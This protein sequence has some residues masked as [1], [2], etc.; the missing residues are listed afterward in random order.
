MAKTELGF[1]G[2]IAKNT[3]LM[4]DAIANG[5]GGFGAGAKKPM[6]SS[7]GSSEDSLGTEIDRLTKSYTTLNSAL[8]DRTKSNK[9]EIEE[10]QNAIH[11]LSIFKDSLEAGAKDTK[12][13]HK[14]WAKHHEMLS[15][16]STALGVF[17]NR[18]D[19]LARIMEAADG[20]IGK[21]VDGLS[22]HMELLAN[23]SEVAYLDNIAII[24]AEKESR[25]ESMEELSKSTKTLTDRFAVAGA[26]AVATIARTS[27]LMLATQQG[28]F[29]MGGVGG[30]ADTV[31]ETAFLGVS[32]EEF[33]RYATKNRNTL[34][35]MMATDNTAGTLSEKALISAG[36]A[37]KRAKE[38][39]DITRDTFGAIGED[40]LNMVSDGIL[41]LSNLGMPANIKNYQALVDNFEE[42]A[43][44][45]DM[46]ASQI[47]S[48]MSE[49]SKITGIQGMALSM[50]RGTD[51][52]NMLTES[53]K[54]LQAS[55][56]MNMEEFIA[57][58]RKMADQRKKSGADRVVEGK[59]VGELAKT[60][61]GFTD[62]ETQLLELGTAFPEMVAAAGQTDEFMRLTATLEN[63]AGTARTEAGAEGSTSDLQRLFVLIN[64]A[65][66]DENQRRVAS[67]RSGAGEAVAKAQ[68]ARIA[69]ANETT[70]A[71]TK[72]NADIAN[73]LGGMAKSPMFQLATF[74]IATIGAVTTGSALGTALGIVGIPVMLGS[75]LAIAGTTIAAAIGLALTAW[76]AHTLWMFNTEETPE[77]KAQ[78]LQKETQDDA[79]FFV[80]D[81]LKGLGREATQK[82]IDI[83]NKEY[84]ASLKRVLADKDPANDAVWQA[85]LKS[86]NAYSVGEKPY[87]APKSGND[88]GVDGANAQGVVADKPA[89]A[90]DTQKQTDILADMLAQVVK[91]LG[92]LLPTNDNEVPTLSNMVM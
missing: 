7:G 70:H 41:T 63:L 75:A 6:F 34:T 84:S 57:F 31:W 25:R 23:K 76:A 5:R 71:V 77:E 35:A 80:A 51:M 17:N 85:R 56:F 89:T 81:I 65:N 10:Q 62:E 46:D 9:D 55:V 4:A 88:S 87:K 45:T 54:G 83:L 32:P 13:Y 73:V 38:F 27:N 52:I 72:G 61:G 79:D 48:E 21:A 24:N 37:A 12:N 28:G 22:N 15:D 60:L 30:F 14:N 36:G 43:K 49:L 29:E 33:T 91:G 20:D 16:T 42:L 90:E 39:T 74:V 82:D 18:T 50:G 59:F 69:A 92:N 19:A 26:A 64:G 66:L 67:D 44:I 1:L 47:F 8:K 3:G 86:L 78:N 53:F 40:S 58:Q 2:D 11:T 68:A